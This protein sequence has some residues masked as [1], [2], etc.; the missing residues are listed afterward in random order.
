[1]ALIAVLLLLCGGALVV[2]GLLRMV[3]AWPAVTSA[4]ATGTV[5]EVTP[6]T[7]AGFRNGGLSCGQLEIEFVDR[8]GRTIRKVSA[9]PRRRR[10]GP[11]AHVPMAYDA[12]DPEG[13]AEPLSRLTFGLAS[14]AACLIVGAAVISWGLLLILSA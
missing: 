3:A 14:G 5:V 11:G 9:F 1:M 6:G 8:E 2:G 10:L 13:T 7:G 12:A 4:R